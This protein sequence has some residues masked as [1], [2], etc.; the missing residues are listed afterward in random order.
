MQFWRTWFAGM[1]E[2]DADIR[3]GYGEPYPEYTGPK[4]RHPDSVGLF[5]ANPWVIGPLLGMATHGGRHWE[6]KPFFRR[7][8]LLVFRICLQTS[9]LLVANK[10]FERFWTFQ[11]NYEAGMREEFYRKQIAAAAHGYPVP[12]EIYEHA[13][14]H[15][16][17]LQ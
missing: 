10:I 14:T 12:R 16:L 4:F 7:P 6:C 1:G 15:N 13:S 17:H 2:G 11:S 5:R 3:M 9:L 8:H